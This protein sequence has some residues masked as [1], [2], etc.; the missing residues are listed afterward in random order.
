MSTRTFFPIGNLSELE[1]N[2]PLDFI[3]GSIDRQFGAS[4]NVCVI[5][6]RMKD[7]SWKLNV[8]SGIIHKYSEQSSLIHQ[9]EKDEVKMFFLQCFI[10]MVLSVVAISSLYILILVKFRAHIMVINRYCQ[11]L[12]SLFFK[13]DVQSSDSKADKLA[14]SLFYMAVAVISIEV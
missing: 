2:Q 5:R 13:G 10:L 8:S 1:S 4:I 12:M 9:I 6:C 7:L 14:I 3:L 11:I